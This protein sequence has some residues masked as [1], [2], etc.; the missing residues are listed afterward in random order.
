MYSF[1]LGAENHTSLK[2]ISLRIINS[3]ILRS[4]FLVSSCPVLYTGCASSRTQGPLWSES[5]SRCSASSCLISDYKLE[6]SRPIALLNTIL[7]DQPSGAAGSG[8]VV[9]GIRGIEEGG[10][11]EGGGKLEGCK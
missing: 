10:R 6:K 9:V 3:S 2:Y 11:L 7:R 8:E 5:S 4:Y 1:K